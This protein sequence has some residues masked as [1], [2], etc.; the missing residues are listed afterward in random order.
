MWPYKCQGTFI[1]PIVNW[2]LG[3]RWKTMV[4]AD[5]CWPTF[6]HS[7]GPHNRI[8]QNYGNRCEANIWD[9]KQR[10]HTLNSPNG[11]KPTKEQKQNRTYIYVEH[12]CFEMSFAQ[13][14]YPFQN[15]YSVRFRCNL[16]PFFVVYILFRDDISE[17]WN[18]SASE[19]CNFWS[20]GA[21]GEG[22]GG[23]AGIDSIHHS[24]STNILE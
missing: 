17:A 6:W 10:W 14:Y 18:R 15:Y 19:I 9:G 23:G 24:L 7:W 13:P 22:R 2:A 20:E 3:Q 4:F 1:P 5:C 21:E 16:S 8:I 11:I 12:R